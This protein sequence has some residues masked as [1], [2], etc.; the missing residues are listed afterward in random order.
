MKEWRWGRGPVALQSE[1]VK[2][3]GV[4]MGAGFETETVEEVLAVV[5]LPVEG[6]S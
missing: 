2:V 6:P 5:F 1:V 4:N 3:G